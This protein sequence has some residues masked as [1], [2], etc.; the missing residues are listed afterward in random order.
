MKYSRARTRTAELDRERQIQSLKRFST[1]MDSSVRLPGGYRIGLDGIIG[2]IPGIGDLAGMAASLYIIVSAHR[3]GAGRSTLVRMLF[4]VGLETVIGS[5][6]LAGDIFDMAFKA[7]NRNMQ[8]LTESIDPVQSSEQLPQGTLRPGFWMIT[9]I[10]MLF[11]VVF[12]ILYGLARLVMSGT[13]PDGTAFRPTSD[14][15]AEAANT[16]PPSQTKSE[17]QTSMR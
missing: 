16:V 8:L 12:I 14:F 6:P 4:N 10:A 13:T 11:A 3:L 17:R 5:V 2:L 1:L 15:Y 9:V 7:N